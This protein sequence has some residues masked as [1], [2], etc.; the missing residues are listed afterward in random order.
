MTMCPLKNR[1]ESYA[2][3]VARG[4]LR[5][6]RT[7]VERA[8][9]TRKIERIVRRILLNRLYSANALSNDE[10]PTFERAAVDVIAC[11]TDAE[12]AS[13]FSSPC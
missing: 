13:F 8:H 3:R 10:I 7:D 12:G 9:K 2:Q 4:S 5:E 6:I 1:R 11:I